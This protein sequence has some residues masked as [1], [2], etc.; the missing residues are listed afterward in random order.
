MGPLVLAS[1]GCAEPSPAVRPA[2]IDVWLAFP[3]DGQRSWTYI[4]ED[5]AVPYLLLA[6]CDGV[7]ERS[8]GYNLYTVRYERVCTPA[9]S[10]CDAGPSHVIRWSSDVRDGIWAH[11]YDIGPLAYAA[12][13]PPIPVARDDRIQLSYDDMSVGDAIVT[14]AGDRE[15]TS[16]LEALEDCPAQLSQVI[17]D[18]AAW[19][20]DVSDGDGR[21]LAGRWWAR[22]T[23][24]VTAFQGPEEG[25]WELSEFTCTPDAEC[26]GDW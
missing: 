5:P 8:D 25:R 24:G 21:P 3:F 18:C 15:W 1:L 13:H 7:A 4:N 14:A 6:T 16:T 22:S 12:G 10:G 9:G 2:V 17:P 11:A 26:D 20:L 19:T 23:V